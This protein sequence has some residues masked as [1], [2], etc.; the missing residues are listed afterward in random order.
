LGVNVNIVCSA[1]TEALFKAFEAGLKSDDHLVITPNMK[2]GQDVI[3]HLLKSGDFKDSFLQS[4]FTTIKTLLSNV[5][6]ELYPYRV[7]ISS[8]TAK[9]ILKGIVHE[10]SYSRIFD[11]IKECAG[12]YD[13]LYRLIIQFKENRYDATQRDT[14]GDGIRRSFI[15]I[16]NEYNAYL[17][18][19]GLYDEADEVMS[20]GEK[21]SSSSI[22]TGKRELNIIGFVHF[23][24]FEERII[25]ELAKHYERVNIYLLYDERDGYKEL[26]SHIGGFISRIRDEFGADIKFLTGIPS[27]DGDNLSY[28]R[29]HLFATYQEK[30]DFA[31]DDDSVEVTC[32]KNIEDEINV[33][34]LKIRKLLA[35]D[36]YAPDDI[37]VIVRNKNDYA[38][39]LE[40]AFKKY[41]IPSDLKRSLPI[42]P[43][44]IIKTVMQPLYLVA[45]DFLRDDVTSFLGSNYI[46][47]KDDIDIDPVELILNK[48][49]VIKGAV[50]YD[51]KL[52][53]LSGVMKGAGGIEVTNTRKYLKDFIYLITREIK[54]ED[55]VSNYKRALKTVLEESFG[56]REGIVSGY[57]L[58]SPELV[59]RD[60]YAYA[61][62]FIAFD[63]LIQAYKVA[64]KGDKKIPISTMIDLLVSQLGGRTVKFNENVSYSFKETGGTVQVFTPEDMFI[65][66][67]KAVFIL[68]MTCD[69]F[70]KKVRPSFLLGGAEEKFE[71]LIRAEDILASERLFFLRLVSLC[72]EKLRLSYIK[73]SG[74]ELAVSA[75]GRSPFIDDLLILIEGGDESRG[76]KKDSV[77]VISEPGTGKNRDD[78]LSDFFLGLSEKTTEEKKRV[79]DYLLSA[80]AGGMYKT[81]FN[82]IKAEFER[83]S[84][85]EFTSYQGNISNQ[86]EELRAQLREKIE[87]RTFSASQ[88]DTF[89]NCPISYFFDKVL[90]LNPIE[91]PELGIQAKDKGTMLHDILFRYFSSDKRP[92]M[93][94]ISGLTDA[95]IGG[96]IST[97]QETIEEIANGY[98]DEN[99]EAHAPMD[100][101]MLK[102]EKKNVID[103]LK[104][105]V[106]HE[107]TKRHKTHNTVMEQERRYEDALMKSEKSRFKGIVPKYVTET[108]G[109]LDKAKKDTLLYE[110]AYFE[111]GFGTKRSSESGESS[112]EHS[113]TSNTVEIKIDLGDGTEI[114]MRGYIDRIDVNGEGARFTIID[115][116][117]GSH[118]SNN[119]VRAGRS[120]QLP[121]Y[122][123][124]VEKS[125][126]KGLKPAC[127][128]Y[129]N[130]SEPKR[131]EIKVAFEEVKG[132]L[133]EFIS[134]MKAGEFF[135]QPKE[136]KSYCNYS[137]IC[138]Y[139]QN[140]NR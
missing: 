135:T 70:P 84:L 26:Y 86:P 23:L 99:S 28:V 69:S 87:T 116:K 48:A 9:E 5:T 138:R 131:T 113:P 100:Q 45:R 139:E 42:A 25:S 2:S 11:P 137:S 8:T 97:E 90:Y 21:F 118:P 71:F 59:K 36:G 123:E 13:D 63:E 47:I 120:F 77:K 88:L 51:V 58:V 4:S 7:A 75:G 108:E 30:D 101:H 29:E 57:E 44:N 125:F 19:N 91:V 76:I 10:Q 6:R 16:Y 14:H 52:K 103:T 24:R 130:L 117:S 17:K 81:I 93:E 12:L 65:R 98:F 18:D 72:G 33:L 105:V 74:R 38:K 122:A 62:F 27:D 121:I 78:F 34:A 54:A 106:R 20:A 40:A 119:D 61:E 1:S 83:E 22:V 79:F 140:S 15:D 109:R 134:M 32:A 96:Y 95:D 104:N 41:G 31:G 56:I 126:L 67:Y 82:N 50:S 115:Y 127:G 80:D 37:A 111:H 53:K 73:G 114:L 129:Y 39:G 46:R 60:V 55:T 68:D 132:R 107:I 3:S 92:T 133:S 89:A 49:G 136:C 35:D 94:R 112:G 85:D 128:I 66:S 64:K 43:L 102:I 110:P 124:Y